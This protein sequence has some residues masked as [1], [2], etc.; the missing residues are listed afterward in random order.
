MNSPGL[1]DSRDVCLRSSLASQFYNST[2]LFKKKKIAM[3]I[4]YVHRR[5]LNLYDLHIVEKDSIFLYDTKHL[6]LSISKCIFLFL[7]VFICLFIYL[8]IFETQSCSVAQSGVW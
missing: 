3:Q 1:S 4:N 8:S 2:Q 5:Q 6:F 7:C